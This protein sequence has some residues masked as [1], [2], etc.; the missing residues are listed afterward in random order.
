TPSAASLIRRKREGATLDAAQLHA[1][2]QGIGNGS[3]SEGQIG[4]FAM[5]VA[6]RGMSVEECR[7]YLRMHQYMPGGAAEDAF[8]QVRVTVGTHHEQIC[9][10]VLRLLQE[11]SAGLLG[12]RVKAQGLRADAVPAQVVE[13]VQP[14]R[15]RCRV[16]VGRMGFL[17]VNDPDLGG[18]LQER[19]GAMHRPRGLDTAVPADRHASWRHIRAPVRRQQEAG[20][21]AGQH[22]LVEDVEQM[23]ARGDVALDHRQVMPCPKHPQRQWNTRP[24]HHPTGLAHTEAM[25][26]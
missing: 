15:R 2:A 7:G 13:R 24:G 25:R 12:R 20:Q 10:H 22:G 5:A 1:L 11:G 26:M 23:G 3:W 17:S 14:Q 21:A 6:W 4:A 9:V 8:A 18:F 19:Q 16:V